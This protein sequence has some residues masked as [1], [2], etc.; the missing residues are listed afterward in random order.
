M[1][2]KQKAWLKPFIE[3]NTDKRQQAETNFEKDMFKLTNNSIYGKSLENVRKH[4]SIKLTTTLART[5]KLLAKPSVVYFNPLTDK[6][7][8]FRLQRL[9]VVLDKPVHLGFAVLDL[10][11]LSMFEFHYDY[12]VPK[13]GNNCKL[14]T[15]DTDSFIYHIFTNDLYRDMQMSHHLFDTSNYPPDHFLFS[16]ENKKIPGKMK[17]ETESVPI[18]RFI[19]LKSKMYMIDYNNT[20]KKVGKGVK[21]SV[22]QKQV[23]SDDYLH[24]L[25]ERQRFSF[26]MTNIRSFDHSLFTIEQRKL[27]LTAYDDKRFILP[28]G[29]RTVP[30]GHYS[31]YKDALSS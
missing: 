19:G 13:Y 14:L 12:I 1:S 31:I 26:S 2:F 21:K 3:F 18:S 28:C 29:H 24:C 20:V 16:N 7:G 17:D 6:L 22:L 5:R 23:T 15:T 4:M 10:S 25:N 30:Y 27:C 11:K 9:K 8:L